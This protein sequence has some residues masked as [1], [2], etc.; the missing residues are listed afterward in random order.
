MT[1]RGWIIFTV[2]PIFIQRSE[3]KKRKKKKR[4][5]GSS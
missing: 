3:E 2:L 1:D 5:G 4:E